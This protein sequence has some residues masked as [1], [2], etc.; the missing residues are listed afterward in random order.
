MSKKDYYKVLQVSKNA[1]QQEIKKSF[2]K[3]AMQYHPDRNKEAGA[4]DKFKEINEA[5]EILSDEDKRSKYDQFGHAAFDG[6]QG[7]GGFGGFGGFGDFNDIFSSF[8]G[9][10][11]RDP[12]APRKGSDMQMRTTI[13]F[14]ESIFGKIIEQSLHKFVNGERKTVETEIKVPSGIENGQQIRL[15]GFGGK[16]ANNGPNG[17]LFILISVKSHKK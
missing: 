11:R 7:H 12:N 8:F 2:R 3:L 9:G 15:T 14:E 6:N 5:Y 10:N 17:D 16:G 13:S 1:E 4:E